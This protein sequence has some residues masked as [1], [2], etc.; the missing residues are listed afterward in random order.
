[1]GI[2]NMIY[3]TLTDQEKE[4]IFAVDVLGWEFRKTARGEF[5]VNKNNMRMFTV[6]QWHPRTDLNHAMMGVEKLIA[7]NGTYTISRYNLPNIDINARHVTIGLED[8]F[9]VSRNLDLCRALVE[10]CICIKRPD[11]FEG[12]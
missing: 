8:N 5:L 1:M 7:E 9:V 6:S 2:T 11:L 12:E 10:A 4:R 3:N